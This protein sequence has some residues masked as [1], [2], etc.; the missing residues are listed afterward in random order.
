MVSVMFK[1]DMNDSD[2]KTF[3]ATARSLLGKGQNVAWA[4]ES[5]CAYTTFFMLSHG[6]TYW[7][8]GLPDFT[9]LLD[10]HTVDG[11]LWGQE[12]YYNDLA[13]IIIPA[14]FYWE[15]SD[16]ENGFQ[17]GYKE[18]DIKTLSKELTAKKIKH[19]LTDKVLEIKLY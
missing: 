10:T 14:Q 11:G 7:S 6:L 12:F 2:W 8:V 13:H 17:N 1:I 4:S 3:L 19:K 9:E 18:Q 15:Q 5:W 16:K